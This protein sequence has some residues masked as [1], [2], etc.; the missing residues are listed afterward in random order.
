MRIVVPGYMGTRD[1][2]S[3]RQVS[4]YLQRRKVGQASSRAA[5]DQRIVVVVFYEKD[6]GVVQETYYGYQLFH[7]CSTL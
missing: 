5:L 7:N 1:A 2:S 6:F 3:R 4:L